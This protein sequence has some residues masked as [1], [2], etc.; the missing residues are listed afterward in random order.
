[1][2]I[3]ERQSI[4]GTF[5]TYIGTILG[6]I[7]TGL[8]FPKLLSSEQ[9]GLASTLVAYSLIF[10]QIASLGF[11]NVTM[12]MFTYFRD[13]EKEHNGFFSLLLIVGFIGF[14]L[15][16]IGV[17]G[18]Y[19]VIYKNNIDNSPLFLD[20][21]YYLIPLILFT[22]FFNLFDSYYNSLFNATRGIVLR[23][24]IQRVFIFISIIL[25][26]L[27]IVDFHQFIFVYIIALSLPA[28]IFLCFLLIEKQFYV[29]P[30]FDF[31]TN[32]LIK[33]M[34]GVGLNSII[35]GFVGIAILQIDRVMLSSMLGLN[36]T[37]VYT[38]S[39]FFASL[40][41]VPSRAITK[42]SSTLIADAWKE[43]NR[44]TIQTI[45]FK[46]SI[47]QLLVGILLFIGIWAN[48]HNVF[49]ILS[50]E[51]IAGKYVIFFVG[52]AS[53]LEMAAG[54]NNII[55]AAS[56]YY[57]YFT[58][59]MII[60]IIFLIAFNVL[61]IP[62]Y[63]ITGA[64]IASVLA[65][66]LL[67]LLRYLFVWKKMKLQPFN[68][69]YIILLL[70]GIFTYFIS[71]LLPVSEYYII[72]IAYRSVIITAVYG[73]LAYFLHISED[74]NNR[75]NIYLIFIKQLIFEHKWKRKK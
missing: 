13:Y 10:T 1:L 5:Y 35:A 51:Y 44:E 8:L 54:G 67:H 73:G 66:L 47:N 57:R 40:I 37:G 28:F 3:I 2:G 16:V 31:L 24:F 18:F 21:Y 27:H 14:V 12:R 69:K 61:F 50:P 30:Q 46:T 74:I 53:L 15:S 36:D 38:I 39:F 60:L 7:N 59:F 72:D 42:I 48:I 75:A 63:G 65:S 9:I 70:I 26:Y 4:R 29:K 11:N 23:E 64:A 6:F 45:Y 52:L 19:S 33:S 71:T 25:F 55:I 41:T 34:V 22:S 62:K 43:N 56:K 68:Y 49:R 58:L 20:Y 17:F 32:D